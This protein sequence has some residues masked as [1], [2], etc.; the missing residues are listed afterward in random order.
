MVHVQSIKKGSKV[1]QAKII[2]KQSQY[3]KEKHLIFKNS[4]PIFMCKLS[5]LLSCFGLKDIKKELFPFNYYALERIK[6]NEGIINEAVN[7]EK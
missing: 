6:I 1:Y 7:S 4:L 2:Y 3:H 5:D